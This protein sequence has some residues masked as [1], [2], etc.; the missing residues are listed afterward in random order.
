MRFSKFLTNADLGEVAHSSGYAWSASGRRLGSTSSVSFEQRKQI[1]AKRK[2]VR[3]YNH[4]K[5]ALRG[6]A[7]SERIVTPQDMAKIEAKDYLKNVI[8]KN[9]PSGNSVL[10]RADVK[11]D[12]SRGPKIRL[13][14]PI[15]RKIPR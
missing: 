15:P 6:V 9:A 7:R 13:K 1:D 3:S 12:I 5:I 11:P 2:A 4:S 8:D 14:E 10:G